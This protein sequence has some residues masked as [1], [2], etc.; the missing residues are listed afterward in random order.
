M[1]TTSMI[2]STRL[3]KSFGVDFSDLGTK[4]AYLLTRLVYIIYSSH[5]HYPKENSMKLIPFSL[6]IYPSLV[7]SQEKHLISVSSFAKIMLHFQNLFS[8]DQRGKTLTLMPTTKCTFTLML[9][10]LL[11][12]PYDEWLKLERF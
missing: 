9:N 5:M 3:H 2:R 12:F 4:S 8:G 6:H 11:H 1:P 7:V 10:I